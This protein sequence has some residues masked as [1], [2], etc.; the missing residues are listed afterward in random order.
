MRSPRPFTADSR[1]CKRGEG[2][3]GSASFPRGPVRVRRFVLGGRFAARFRFQ[4]GR[5]N[6]RS[7]G[8]RF[9]TSEFLVADVT[10]AVHFQQVCEGLLGAFLVSIRVV[11]KA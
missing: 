10:F 4:G 1:D 9:Y 11:A 2:I 6:G 5:F 7:T 3:G 8:F